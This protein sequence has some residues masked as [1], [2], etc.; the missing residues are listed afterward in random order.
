MTRTHT[1]R[2]TAITAAF[3]LVLTV[4]GCSQD[5]GEAEVVAVEQSPVEVVQSPEETEEVSA[6]PEEEEEGEEVTEEVTSDP[7]EEQYWNT[8]SSFDPGVP[9][10]T[11]ALIT[12]LEVSSHGDYDRV[13]IEFTGEG[14]LGWNAQYVAQAIEQGRGEPIAIDGPAFLQVGVTG[15][16]FPTT[17]EENAVYYSGSDVQSAGNIR[18]VYDSSF[19]GITQVIIGMDKERPFDVYMLLNP[20]RVV[21]DVQN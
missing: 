1:A 4:A 20:L 19:E 12:G 8:S 16:T 21:I 3:A 7:V 9:A 10:E 15:T 13:S 2:F 6:T 14:P 17:D 5:T 18:A 11:P